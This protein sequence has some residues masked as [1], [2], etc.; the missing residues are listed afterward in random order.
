MEEH[1]SY[2]DSI[3]GL[4]YDINNIT[5]TQV[6]MRVSSDNK[7]SDWIFVPLNRPTVI[8]GHEFTVIKIEPINVG[9]SYDGRPIVV[10]IATVVIK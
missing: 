2:G 9:T 3:K 1:H 6:Q 10:N 8:L 5:A 4:T 7:T